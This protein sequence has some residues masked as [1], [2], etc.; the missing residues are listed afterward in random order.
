MVNYKKACA[1]LALFTAATIANS[2][3]TPSIFHTSE[4]FANWG[5]QYT[6]AADAWALGFTGKGVRIGIADDQAQLTHPEFAGRVYWPSRQAAF[7]NPEYP[8]F[9]EHGTHVMGIAAAA[10]DGLG[11]I[12]VAH[13]A[14]IAHV[15]VV[16]S[17]GY[18]PSSN[19]TQ[20][21][22]D[23][24]A[25]VMNGS[26]GPGATPWPLIPSGSYVGSPNPNYRIVDFQF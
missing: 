20:G 9:P 13:E 2:Q 3:S 5:L 17:P 25:S 6:Y 24:K 1:S 7:P 10:R 22:L 26:F 4:Y 19:W 16:S 15:A 14:S 12:G 23:A 21:L 18:P 8:N 11:M